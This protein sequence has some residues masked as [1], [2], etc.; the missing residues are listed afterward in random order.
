ML[1]KVDLLSIALILIMVISTLSLSATSRIINGAN[2]VSWKY[3]ALLVGRDEV[4]PV[5]TSATGVADFRISDNETMMMRYRVNLTGTTNVTGGHI[6][7]GKI[8]QN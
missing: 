8:G 5:T 6:Y 4:P 3:R 1:H 7:V 2:A